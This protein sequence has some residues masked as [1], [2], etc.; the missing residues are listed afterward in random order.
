MWFR[1]IVFIVVVVIILAA[2][3][4][5]Y[6]IYPSEPAPMPQEE[7][8][9]IREPEETGKVYSVLDK[10]DLIRVENPEPNQI[11]TSPLIIK[12][13]ARGYWFFEADFPV[14]LLD[15]EENLI[16]LEI[17]TAQSEW[18]T[19][20]FVPFEAVMEFETPLGEKGIL[21]F[22][23]DNPSGLPENADEL[24]IPVLFD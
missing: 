21:V 24:R 15:D 8:E 19:E 12:G 10:T 17:A 20:D 13:E 18:M 23:K 14:K 3:Y 4:S 11:I 16:A 5:I 2:G 7:D 9:E 1:I 22:E 6:Q